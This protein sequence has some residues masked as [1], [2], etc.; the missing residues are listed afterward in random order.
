VWASLLRTDPNDRVSDPKHPDEPS[1]LDV[2]YDRGSSASRCVVDAQ[3]TK[4][5]LAAIVA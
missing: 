3:Y 4:M 2:S 1:R 5:T